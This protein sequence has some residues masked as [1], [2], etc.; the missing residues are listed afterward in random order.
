MAPKPL[1]DSPGWWLR[2]GSDYPVRV[3]VGIDGLFRVSNATGD[4]PEA[5]QGRW[6]KV[7]LPVFP[8]CEQ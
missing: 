1:P 5:E 3:F 7:E 4:Y 6:L 2:E 8:E